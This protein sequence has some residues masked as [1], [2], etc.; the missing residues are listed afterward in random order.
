MYRDDDDARARRA[1]ALIDEIAELERAKLAQATT[2]Q[3]LES[4]KLELI[5][6]QAPPSVAPAERPGLATHIIVFGTTAASTFVGYT[7]LF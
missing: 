7:L 4:A 5:E 3:R 6:L 2:E 1:R